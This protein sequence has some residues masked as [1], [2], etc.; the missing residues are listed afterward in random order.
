[1]VRHM[2]WGIGMVTKPSG[3]RGKSKKLH[4]WWTG[5]F[6]VVKRLSKV[7]YR[8]QHVKNRA[9][10]LVVHFD[11]LKRCH[12]DVR[13]S[14]QLEAGTNQPRMSEHPTC[15]ESPLKNKFGTQLE[16]VEDIDG[17]DIHNVE[18]PTPSPN[19][20]VHLSE[21]SLPWRYPTRSRCPP[22]FY[23]K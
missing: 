11:R 4:R 10:W 3:A 12:P 13:L 5:P 6:K 18:Q 9:K 21:P 2:R 15:L 20:E 8:I 1:M 14:E 7:T 23:N 19:R 22:D 16:V 17:M